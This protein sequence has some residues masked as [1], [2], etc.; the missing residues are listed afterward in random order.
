M[1]ELPEVEIARRNLE[2]WLVGRRILRGRV[3]DPL[4]LR[5][6]S[7]RR[8][9]QAL[10]GAT[11]RGVGR[12]G[13]HLILNLGKRGKVTSHFGMSGK[14]VI[15]DAT[16]PLPRA[17]RV[18]LYLARG[19]K[20]AFVDVRRLGA[21]Q[22]VDDVVEKKLRLLGIEPLEAEFTPSRFAELLESARLPIKLF[23]MD[24]RRIAGLGNIHAAEAL[25][26]GRVH[27][28]RQSASLSKSE[29]RAVHRGIR[30]TLNE[31]L[32]KDDARE[33]R[34][35]HEPDSVNRFLIYGR[36]GDPCPRCSTRI[37]RIVQGGR[38]TFY[39]PRCQPVK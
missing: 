15:R 25:F 36:K 26:R 19:R 2:R 8:L 37:E 1:P 22:F 12:R 4:A 3:L 33:L 34:Y 10:R 7:I 9:T 39:C 23:L 5:G 18:V 27:P 6:Q 29:I 14:M 35:L 21:F 16:E 38:S 17:S 30:D 13:K 31:T 28:K 20:L 32:Q 24:Q 11:V